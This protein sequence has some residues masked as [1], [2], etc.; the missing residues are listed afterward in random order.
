MAYTQILIAGF[1]G[2]G[3][4]FAGKVLAYKGLEAGRS[5]LSRSLQRQMRKCSPNRR[6][7]ASGRSCC[8]VGTG[9]EYSK[10]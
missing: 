3:V 10:Q 5:H 2:Q 8:T 4:L 1:G 9:N 7:R 6:G